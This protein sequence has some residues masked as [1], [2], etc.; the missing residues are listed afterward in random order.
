MDT[1]V[2][3]ERF[4]RDYMGPVFYFSL[5]KTGSREEA[6][7]LTSDIALSVLTS[8]KRCSPPAHFS[9]WVWRIA[10]CRYAR[11]ADARHIARA[12]L[13][14]CDLADFDIADGDTPEDAVIESEQYAL[15]RRELAFIAREYR[16]LLAAHYLEDIGVKALAARHGI[17]DGTVKS[18]L[19]RARK[20]LQE[21]MNMARE[22][23]KRSYLPE[24]VDFSASGNQPDGL[25]WSA[26]ERKIP[27]NI[28]LE[29]SNNPSTAEELATELGIALPYMEEEIG[30]LERATLLRK[31]DD[32]K[33]ITN[34]FI[35]DKD[36][37]VEIYNIEKRGS[38]TRARLLHEAME[39]KLPE[40]LAVVKPENISETDFLWTIWLFA[41]NAV[42]GDMKH[43]SYG[44]FVRPNGGNWGFCGFERH[45]LIA[46]NASVNHNCADCKTA[47]F[48]QFAAFGQ[49]FRVY[50]WEDMF[51]STLAFFA[52]LLTSGRKI[53]TLTDSEM[54]IWEGLAKRYAHVGEDGTAVVDVLVFRDGAHDKMM[55]ILRTHPS[56]QELER[57]TEALFEEIRGVLM[58]NSNAVLHETMDYYVSM[59]MF[60][61]RGML[62]ND[63]VA[64]GM[65]TVPEHPA[66]SNAGMYLIL[67]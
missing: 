43:H 33:Y 51:S 38:L 60:Q 54:G 27:K 8:L 19:S 1:A 17:P 3:A 52:E 29:A 11:W 15:L 35:A 24:D 16:E 39:A 12:H 42:V 47:A 36:C 26:V 40:I 57:Q 21:G 28:L 65:V 63:A 45:N 23:G 46:E 56:M 10:R 6:E 48:A 2:Y 67:K 41:I 9:A 5:K 18:R 62:M 34:F 7:E 31:L 20:I 53:D 44:G 37:Q 55:E 49:G 14:T 32:G 64:A 50:N 30:L 58:Q 59:F 22:F 4:A 13:A 61:I 25:P 66:S